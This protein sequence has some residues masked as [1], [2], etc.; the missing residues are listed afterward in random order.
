MPPP[1]AVLANA[2]PPGVPS[3]GC[4]GL[5]ANDDEVV[6]S[7]YEMVA[8]ETVTIAGAIPRLLRDSFWSSVPSLAGIFPGPRAAA[9]PALKPGDVEFIASLVGDDLAALGCSFAEC[10]PPSPTAG[11]VASAKLLEVAIGEEDDDSPDPMTAVSFRIEKRPFC[12]A[13]TTSPL[14]DLILTV[15]TVSL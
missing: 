4:C 10:L 11:A 7:G 8:G 5:L 14:M 2:T 3:C 1:A 6:T 9:V 13:T 12:F 15:G